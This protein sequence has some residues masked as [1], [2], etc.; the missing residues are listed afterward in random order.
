MEK[1]HGDY[2]R[3]IFDVESETS[4]KK[5]W[6][7]VKSLEVDRIGIIWNNKLMSQA[8]QRAEALTHQYKSVFTVETLSP[9]PPKDQVI[10]TLWL[11]STYMLM[12]LRNYW[13]H[14]ILRKKLAQ[15]RSPPGC[16]KP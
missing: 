6:G 3:N 11:T 10:G 9:C 14:L 8:N 7:Y 1:A 4:L 5:L 15:I 13:H 16:L 2:V 12:E